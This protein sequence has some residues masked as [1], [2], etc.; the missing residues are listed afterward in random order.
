MDQPAGLLANGL[1][2]LGVGMAK[3][4][5]RHAGQR[6]EI[7]LAAAIPQPYTFA[8]DEGDRLPAVGFHQMRHNFSESKNAHGGKRRRVQL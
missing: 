7:A 3:A 8:L 2:Q 1:C 4:V 6:I 5:H